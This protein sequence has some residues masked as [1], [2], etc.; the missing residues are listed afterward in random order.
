M[1]QDTLLLR[2]YKPR[3]ALVTEDHTPQRARFPQ[4]DAHNHL[5]RAL[6]DPAPLLTLMDERMPSQRNDVRFDATGHFDPARPPMQ[7]LNRRQPGV[8]RT[9]YDQG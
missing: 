7:T 8:P 2:D 5:R 4:V 1:P 3:T 9:P 6:D